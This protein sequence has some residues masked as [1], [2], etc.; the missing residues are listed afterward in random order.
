[1]MTMLVHRICHAPL[2]LAVLVFLES[3]YQ[4]QKKMNDIQFNVGIIYT[5]NINLLKI[6]KS[7]WIKYSLLV[8]KWACSLAFIWVQVNLCIWVGV[9][10]WGWI[11]NV[12]NGSRLF[13]WSSTWVRLCLFG[14]VWVL[15]GPFETNWGLDQL[16]Q[17]GS[18]ESVW[19]CLDSFGSSWVQLVPVES[20]WVRLVCF[21]PS[22]LIIH[23]PVG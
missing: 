9:G 21:S 12:L 18:V 19:V 7:K 13:C 16:N 4:Q 5:L 22:M 17:F 20:T 23:C 2:W 15:L 11:F 6:K 3:F 8:R 1:M 10:M 14:S